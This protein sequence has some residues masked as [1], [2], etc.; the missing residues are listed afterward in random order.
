[1]PFEIDFEPIGR[2]GKCDPDESLLDAARALEIGIASVCD[3]A[4]TCY[5]CRIQFMQGKLSLPSTS[6]LELFST[7]EIK[8]GWRLACQSFP[9]EDCRVYI[10]ADS[11]TTPQRTQVEGVEIGVK[12][13]AA[14]KS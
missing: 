10:P 12:L 1:M 9:M 7:E 4:G 2:R 8:A 5:S 6:E 14:V 13:A 3:G 11:M